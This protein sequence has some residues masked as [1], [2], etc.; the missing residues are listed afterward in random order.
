M[1]PIG[2]VFIVLNSLLAGGF[3]FVSGTY[4]QQQHNYK[5][6][7]EAANK[8]HEAKVAD[9][10][11]QID[12]ISGERTTFENAKTASETQLNDLKNVNAQLNDENKRLSSKLDSLEGDVKQLVAA[13]QAANSEMKA[14]FDK[15]R[16]AYDMSIADGKVKDE[17]VREKDT[18]VAENRDLKTKI[19]S[20]EENV[21]GR[22]SKIAGLENDV[23]RLGLLVKVAETQGFVRTSAAPNLSGL[24]TNAT[25]RLCTIQVSDNPG[26]V[27]IKEALELGKVS[28]AIFDA[29]G[30]KAEA[31]AERFEESANAVLCKIIPVKGTVKEGDKAATKTP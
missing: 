2:R 18:A 7:L 16:A 27:N 9:L 24:V 30:Y 5:A 21:T 10:S 28:F 25:D 11:G 26:N 6:K 8:A 17:A 31:V 12:R 23:S 19:A 13:A 4:L 20:L 22:D 3:L 29:S 14:A 15:A 1:S